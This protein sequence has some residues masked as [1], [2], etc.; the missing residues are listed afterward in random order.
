MPVALVYLFAIF[1]APDEGAVEAKRRLILEHVSLGTSSDHS[2]VE[3]A[4][5]TRVD[6]EPKALVW[7]HHG[8]G[9]LHLHAT[10]HSQTL[11]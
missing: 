2:A 10:L 4:G 1:E 7:G 6:V 11:G 8:T 3:K 5:L 9:N